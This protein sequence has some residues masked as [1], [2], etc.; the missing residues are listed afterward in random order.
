VQRGS[1]KKNQRPGWSEKKECR[2]VY[3]GK[4]TESSIHV[5]LLAG[6]VEQEVPTLSCWMMIPSDSNWD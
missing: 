5:S 6:C 1:G 4:E 3:W 2:F